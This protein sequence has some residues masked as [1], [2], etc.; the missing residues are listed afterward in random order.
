MTTEVTSRRERSTI[1]IVAGAVFAALV[2]V[3]LFAFRAAESTQQAQAKANQL[4]AALQQAGAR[5]PSQDQIVRV[6]GDDGGAVCE[7][8][9][10]ALHKSVLLSQLVNG[11][12]GPGTR[13]VIAD[14]RV[15]KGQL[16]VIG[17][18]CPNELPRFQEFVN[19]LKLEQGTVK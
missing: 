12:G 11:S 17:I 18:Y 2:L 7:N 16:L 10:D 6:L 8:P 3:A 9:S 5:A 15:V 14:S 13:P 1:Y 4:I 19:T